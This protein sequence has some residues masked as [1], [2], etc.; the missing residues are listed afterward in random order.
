[1]LFCSEFP[2]FKYLNYQDFNLMKK[3]NTN[4][5]KDKLIPNSIKKVGP[6]FAIGGGD[7]VL[8][9]KKAFPLKGFNKE[10]IYKKRE[11]F[12]KSVEDKCN[13]WYSTF[14]ECCDPH[15]RLK[16]LQNFKKSNYD[17]IPKQIEHSL[18]YLIHSLEI[19][20]DQESWYIE[21]T[22]YIEYLD[23]SLGSPRIGGHIF[24]SIAKYLIENIVLTKKFI[25]H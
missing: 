10:N 1:M 11:E 4:K 15:R 18:A 25:L 21:I 7:L 24:G 20:I 16:G 14:P 19:F 9:P 22:D 3:E 17:F 13:K 12:F 2:I 6:I 5:D 23:M 8:S